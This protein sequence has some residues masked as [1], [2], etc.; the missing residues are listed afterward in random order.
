MSSTTTAGTSKLLIK[1]QSQFMA[2]A[3]RLFKNKM[4]VAN[5]IILLLLI[6]MAILAP[7]IIPYDY[8]VIDLSIFLQN[9]P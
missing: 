1:K 3:K 9:L 8:T 4:A 6:F 5:L 7:W 2:V